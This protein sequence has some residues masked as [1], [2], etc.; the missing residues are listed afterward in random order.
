MCII[1]MSTHLI[2]RLRLV[3]HKIY[4]P[5]IPHLSA[6]RYQVTVADT[7]NRTSTTLLFALLCLIALDVPAKCLAPHRHLRP[8]LQNLVFSYGQAELFDPSEHRYTVLAFELMA[9]YRPLALVC[10]QNVAGRSV[11]G[12]LY[13][14]LGGCFLFHDYLFNVRVMERCLLLGAGC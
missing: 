8:T 13:I 9:E 2:P 10:N 4:L 14:T 6:L 5:Y 11:K 1:C 3:W 7:S 12:Q